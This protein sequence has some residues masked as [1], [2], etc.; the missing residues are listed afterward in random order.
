MFLVIVIMLLSL[1]P[2]KKLIEINPVPNSPRSEA[3]VQDVIKSMNTP[4]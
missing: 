1:I 2:R 4:A 3:I